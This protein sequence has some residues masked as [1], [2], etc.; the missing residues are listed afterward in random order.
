M[1]STAW[2]VGITVGSGEIP[3]RKGLRQGL[4]IIII[5]IIHVY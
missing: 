1:E 3:Q 5:I 4:I 2:A